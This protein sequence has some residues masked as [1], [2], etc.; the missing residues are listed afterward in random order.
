MC[1][2]GGMFRRSIYCGLNDWCIGPSSVEEA[3]SKNLC[4]KGLLWMS[5]YFF[6]DILFCPMMLLLYLN[7]YIAVPYIGTASCDGLSLVFNCSSC[8]NASNSANNQE[9]NG[10]CELNEANGI[11]EAKGLKYFHNIIQWDN[12]I[13]QP[14][15]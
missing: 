12:D 1:S 6:K 9:C 10:N 15:D 2:E 14:N 4:I 7:T 11:C 13:F 3:T 8:T 5:I